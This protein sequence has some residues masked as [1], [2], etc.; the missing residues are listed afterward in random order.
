A[1]SFE[2]VREK[3]QQSASAGDQSDWIRSLDARQ[4]KVLPLFNEW[5][6]I[7]TPQIAELLKLSPRGARALA[8]KWVRDGFLVIASPSKRGRT[9]RLAH[10]P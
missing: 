1:A 4:R 3:M 2:A 6:E 9:Y 5:A 7:T 8:L 10:T